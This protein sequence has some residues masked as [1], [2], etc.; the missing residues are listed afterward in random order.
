MRPRE[1][2][3]G[4]DAYLDDELPEIILFELL[5]LT[6]A[7][8]HGSVGQIKH[9]KYDMNLALMAAAA[10]LAAG[11]RHLEVKYAYNMAAWSKHF[12]TKESAFAWK[13]DILDCIILS[14]YVAMHG[15]ITKALNFLIG[16]KIS[17]QKIPDPDIIRKIRVDVRSVDGSQGSTATLTCAAVSP[18]VD[19]WSPFVM[20]PERV[21]TLCSRHFRTLCMPRL[22]RGRSSGPVT[23]VKHRGVVQAVQVLTDHAKVKWTWVNIAAILG[24]RKDAK[25]IW[26]E[27]RSFETGHESVP[28]P[29]V[30]NKLLQQPRRLETQFRGCNLTFLR[31]FKKFLPMVGGSSKSLHDITCEVSLKTDPLSTD[32]KHILAQEYRQLPGS[33]TLEELAGRV[34]T[35]WEEWRGSK[36][37]YLYN[38]LQ[39]PIES[40]PKTR[41]YS[42]L[43]N[44]LGEST[45]CE[46]AMGRAEWLVLEIISATLT[47][48]DASRVHNEATPLWTMLESSLGTTRAQVTLR[49]AWSAHKMTFDGDVMKS[50]RAGAN[51]RSDFHVVASVPG[52][53]AVILCTLYHTTNW[54][55]ELKTNREGYNLPE[56]RLLAEGF[57]SSLLVDVD[58]ACQAVAQRCLS[59]RGFG[60]LQLAHD[61]DAS[62]TLDVGAMLASSNTDHDSAALE[63]ETMVFSSSTDTEFLADYSND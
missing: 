55:Q 52:K 31:L 25:E 63:V 30:T 36:E 7:E 19:T 9:S 39:T 43:I 45:W 58:H 50:G 29:M 40:T 13:L 24:I 59:L 12:V 11:V 27:W 16:L 46:W 51:D 6:E 21:V 37:G 60:P 26:K 14:P 44:G 2:S 4:I 49:I 34:G 54:P 56:A 32:S 35:M 57:T 18:D 1:C 53:T 3:N 42:A 20:Q 47:R 23:K 33:I 5:Q 22:S 41:L 15:M 8:Q 62:A 48:L 10:I 17:S 61:G 38:L 28:Q